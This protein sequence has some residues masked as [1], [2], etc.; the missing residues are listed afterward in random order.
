MTVPGWRNGIRVGLKIQWLQSLEGSSPSL[1]TNSGTS[2]SVERS[3]WD[4]EV[5]GSI[6]WS[7]TRDQGCERS[8]CSYSLVPD[9]QPPLTKPLDFS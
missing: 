3:V 6:P 7:P 2:S 1:G 5:Q 4:R 9:I 8:E